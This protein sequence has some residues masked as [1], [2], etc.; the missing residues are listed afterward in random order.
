MKLVK[1]YRV[2]DVNKKFDHY[3]RV[4][5]KIINDK[6]LSLCAFKILISLISCSK[7]FEPSMSWLTNTVGVSKRTLAK[8]IKELKNLGYLESQ[9]NGFNDYQWTILI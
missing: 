8:G 7:K 2:E 4:P 6:N 9:K 3:T 5:T 1:K